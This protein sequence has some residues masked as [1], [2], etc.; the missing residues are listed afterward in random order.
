[1]PKVLSLRERTDADGAWHQVLKDVCYGCGCA[2]FVAEDDR[3]LVWEPGAQRQKPC[4]D[5]LC[6]CHTKPVIGERRG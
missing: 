3:D 4:S 1:M 6:E 2:Y 5:D